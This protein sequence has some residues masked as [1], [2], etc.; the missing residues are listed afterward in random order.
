VSEDS[1][2]L[3]RAAL[4]GSLHRHGV[5]FV[6]VGGLA[7]QAHGAT[8]ATKD[9]DICPE[10]S[11]ANLGRLAGALTELDARLKIG[12]GSVDVLEIAIDARTI[13]NIEIGAWRTAVGDVDVLLGIPRESRTVLARYEQLAEHAI[14]FEVDQLRILVASLDDIIRS[15]E[16]AN[17]DK[18]RAALAELRPLRDAGQ[19]E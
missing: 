12:D 5:R 10:W 1:P 16:V 8:R 13:H 15:K 19:G 11:D 17:R 18:D 7:A 14:E 6:L 2:P 4:L 9:A 3:D